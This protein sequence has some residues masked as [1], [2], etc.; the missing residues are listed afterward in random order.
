MIIH[1]DYDEQQQE[2]LGTK[3]EREREKSSKT[4]GKKE[5]ENTMRKKKD[6]RVTVTQGLCSSE[7]KILPPVRSASVSLQYQRNC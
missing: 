7:S 4:G 3:R 6:P 2:T 5:N 1:E